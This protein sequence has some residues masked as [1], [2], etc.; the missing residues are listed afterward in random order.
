[1]GLIIE[2]SFLII[3]AIIFLANLYFISLSKKLRNIKNETELSGFEIAKK[4]SEKVSNK[5]PHI[6]KKKGKFL[7]HYDI[8]RNVIKLSPE[9]FDGTDLYAA[10]VAFNIALE[11]DAKKEKAPKGHNLSS[12]IVMSSYIMIILGVLLN[13]SS[14][15]R[16][17]F[18]LFI[19]ALILE[20]L[21]LNVFGK[22]L[23]DI[24][25]IYKFVEKN[26]IIKP[27]DE[28]KEYMIFFQLLNVINLPYRFINNFR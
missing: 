22:T 19:M 18:I 17:G 26:K 8:N 9:V 16:F 20:M 14:I 24:E 11:T 23:E 21:I 3:V 5:E 2:I 27:Y 13:N 4:I 6:I 10:F 7:D 25:K 1:M 28:Y 12:F 15:M